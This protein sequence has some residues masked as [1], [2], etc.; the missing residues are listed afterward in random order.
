MKQIENTLVMTPSEGSASRE[1]PSEERADVFQV[2]YQ[3]DRF[4]NLESKR[5]GT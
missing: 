4:F 5:S 1:L 3:L 2:M